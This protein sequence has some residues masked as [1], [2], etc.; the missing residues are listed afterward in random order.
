[1]GI[2]SIFKLFSKAN[3]VKEEKN[4]ETDYRSF[5]RGSFVRDREN[6]RKIIYTCK[7]D[8]RDFFSRYEF[9]YVDSETGNIYDDSGK[10]VTE[11]YKDKIKQ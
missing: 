1:M 11:F 5:A 2:R 6:M 4:Y 3:E 9:L 10:D 8:E 7:T